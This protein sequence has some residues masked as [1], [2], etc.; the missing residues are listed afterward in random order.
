MSASAKPPVSRRKFWTLVLVRVIA[1][2]TLLW[3]GVRWLERRML[4]APTREWEMS[5]DDIE[6]PA[7]S[8]SLET[9]DGVKLSAVWLP[10]AEPRGV[11]VLCH[12]NAGNL[13]H[14]LPTVESWRDLG[15]SM[16]VFD[17]RGYGK[18]EGK[19]S[20]KGL[21]LDTRAAY[22]AAVRLGGEPP[23]LVGRSLGTVPAVLIASELPTRGL[24]L[25]S[26]LANAATMASHVLPIPGLSKIL[27]V[28][29]DNLE[30]IAQVRCPILIL[31][32]AQDEVIPFDQGRLVFDAAPEPKQFLPLANL[33]HNDSRDDPRILDVIRRFWDSLPRLP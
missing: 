16:L 32:G 3:L 6:P 2:P 9:E 23:I 30:A 33:G 31:H 18:S 24:M 25:D 8:I 20:E 26:P 12:G 14:R 4:F 28:R 5:L 19:P 1:Y 7:E 29:L 15:Y 17:Y 11:V 13:S 27:S 10:H 22:H 21:L